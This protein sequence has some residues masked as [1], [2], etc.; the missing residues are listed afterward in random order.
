MKRLSLLSILFVLLFA[1]CAHHN[2]VRPG[3]DNLHSIN[4]IIDIKEQG[5]ANASKQA[6]HYCDSIDRKSYTVVSE[7]TSYIGEMDEA[8]YN[9]AM[10]ASKAA[11]RLQG[12]IKDI[13]IGSDIVKDVVGKGYQYTMTFKCQ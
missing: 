10:K 5:Y 4:L 12:V 8:N 13:G 7:K 9:T 1:S 11:K 6:A 3:A 2:D